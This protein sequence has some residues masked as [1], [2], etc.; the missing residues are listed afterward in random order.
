M[1]QIKITCAFCNSSYKVTQQE[2]ARQV[3]CPSCNMPLT[4]PAGKVQP[5]PATVRSVFVPATS[6]PQVAASPAKP[7]A[8]RIAQETPSSRIWRARE[9]VRILVILL[10][11]LW[12]LVLAFHALL[13]FRVARTDAE[14]TYHA[15]HTLRSLTYVLL[16]WIAFNLTAWMKCLESRDQDDS[17]SGARST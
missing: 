11:L 4:V 6:Q 13:L 16:L 10:L 3:D 12:H 17:T 14:V 5:Q 7:P 15:E 1:K 8:V 2:E 9:N